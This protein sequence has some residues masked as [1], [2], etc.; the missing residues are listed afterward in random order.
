M[1]IAKNK[2]ELNKKTLSSFQNLE[3]WKRSW[4]VAVL[5]V[6]LI[7]LAFTI[8]DGKIVLKSIPFLVIG[9]AVFP[10]YI[11]LLKIIFYRQNKKF[12]TIMLEYTFTENKLIV[13]GENLATKEETELNYSSLT[14]VKETKKYI[15]LYI[16]KLSALVVDK[17][18]F[19]VGSAE[20][21]MNL[22]KLK[23]ESKKRTI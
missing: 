5:A 3:M 19:S 23:K 4:L 17:N 10:F 8:V 7:V 2:T 12:Q 14:K 6:A 11:I 1:E 21:V 22:L 18:N 15:F 16:N 13:K 9:S 20:K